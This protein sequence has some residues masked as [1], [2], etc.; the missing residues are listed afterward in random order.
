MLW[1]WHGRITLKDLSPRV[2]GDGQTYEIA[3]GADIMMIRLFLHFD[4]FHISLVCSR[5]SVENGRA[6]GNDDKVLKGDF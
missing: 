5:S 3:F 2:V 4:F 6:N 1:P